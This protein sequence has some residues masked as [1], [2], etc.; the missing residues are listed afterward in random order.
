MNSRSTVFFFP[1][2]G[3]SLLIIPGP[4]QRGDRG[5]RK[6]SAGSIGMAILDDDKAGVP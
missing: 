4:T 1:P 5:E 3:L 2:F 6:R